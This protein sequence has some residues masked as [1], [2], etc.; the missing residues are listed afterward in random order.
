MTM[1]FVMSRGTEKIVQGF[2]IS[3]LYTSVGDTESGNKVLDTAAV[4][5]M[6]RT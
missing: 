3:T 4:L 1:D 6:V 5:F 2:V